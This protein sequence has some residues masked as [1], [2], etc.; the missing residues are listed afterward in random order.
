ML[1]DLQP[2]FLFCFNIIRTDVLV[3]SVVHSEAAGNCAELFEPDSL[4]KVSCMNI[5]RNNR[6]ELKNSESVRFCLNN[7]VTNQLFTDVQ[8]PAFKRNGIACVCDMAAS[9]DI[10]RVKDVHSVDLAVLADRNAA[11]GLLSKKIFCTLIREI[12]LLRKSNALVNNLVPYIFHSGNIVRTVFSYNNIF[13]G[14]ILF[15][16]IT[17]CH[18]QGHVLPLP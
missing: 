10:V 1:Y 15:I 14:N 16:S 2:D 17:F 13:H 6:I 7:T 4:I 11:I 9:A 8:S 12:F 18:C 3:M 5:R